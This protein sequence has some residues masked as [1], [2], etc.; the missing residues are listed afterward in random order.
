MPKTKTVRLGKAE[1][2]FK[3]TLWN[4]IKAQNMQS[5]FVDETLKDAKLRSDFC[6]VVG[7]IDSVR[8]AGLNADWKPVDDTATESEFRVCYSHFMEWLTDVG[9]LDAFYAGPFKTINDL[10]SPPADPVEIPTAALTEEEAADP[11]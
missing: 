8:F 10:K 2:R 3:D 7:H 6:Y 1:F 11:N 5:R 9:G 4:E